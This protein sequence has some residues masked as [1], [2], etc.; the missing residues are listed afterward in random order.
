MPIITTIDSEKGIR[1]HTVT[2][3]VTADDFRTALTKVH[4]SPDSQSTMNGLWDLRA[5]TG[6][7]STVDID[8]MADFVGSQWGNIGPHKIALVVSR[9]VDFGLARMY[10]QLL[11][12]QSTIELMVFRDSEE[13]TRWLIEDDG[14]AD[15]PLGPQ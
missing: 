11:E 3:E 10:E 2:G 7:F 5:A 14:Q 12:M 1:I 13:A 15:S 9:D 8:R 6:D 4:T